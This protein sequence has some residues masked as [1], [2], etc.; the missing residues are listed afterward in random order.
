L[1]LVSWPILV[2]NWAVISLTPNDD[3]ADTESTCSVDEKNETTRIRAEL[4]LIVLVTSAVL[5]VSVVYF[6]FVDPL[7]SPRVSL[8]HSL[9][10]RRVGGVTSGASV[11]VP[12]THKAGC[13]MVSDSSSPGSAHP[14]C[15][16]SDGIF[17]DPMGSIRVS[18]SV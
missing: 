6:T 16:G 13:C 12:A 3:E 15:V 11:Q 8:W 2:I 4:G 1:V 5:A 18:D 7:R 9:G 14:G 10:D 17:P